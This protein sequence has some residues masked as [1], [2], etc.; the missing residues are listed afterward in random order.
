MRRLLLYFLIILLYTSCSNRPPI[1]DSDNFKSDSIVFP[2]STYEIFA[3]DIYDD[4]IYFISRYDEKYLL[5]Y[6]IEN[7]IIDTIIKDHEIIDICAVND[8]CIFYADYP[9]FGNYN[10]KKTKDKTY[11][12][13]KRIHETVSH[14][15]WK[16][17]FKCVPVHP[18]NKLTM[19]DENSG[20]VLC[21]KYYIWGDD[22]SVV[23]DNDIPVWL[24]FDIAAD[25][26]IVPVSFFGEYPLNHP[27]DNYHNGGELQLS[28][29]HKYKEIIT[30]TSVDDF[31]VL[32]DSLGNRKHD[33]Y[34]GSQLYKY[35]PF[36]KENKNIMAESQK[37]YYNTTLYSNILFDEYRNLYYRI[38]TV[39]RKKDSE[40]MTKDNFVD[41]IIIV[42]DEKMNI[43][44]EV[45]FNGENYHHYPTLV[46]EKG[47]LIYEKENK[48]WD[49]S[50]IGAWFL[51]E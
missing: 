8:T 40:S 32:C 6:D 37:H 43:K 42:A 15:Y 21:V 24:R 34:L 11:N 28:Y 1:L 22:Y 4:K 7:N 5:S 50:H 2:L 9:E 3:C 38:M 30:H 49:G 17:D 51:F 46:G 36:P 16:D 35:S 18:V 27:K 33:V 10:V 13:F 31:V 47:L 12:Y 14:P 44:Y 48:K 26:S 25:S 23:L 19:I 45:F 41:F 29:N 39:P 20:I